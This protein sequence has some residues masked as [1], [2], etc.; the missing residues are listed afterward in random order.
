MLYFSSKGEFLF[1]FDS[2]R[3][4][5][6]EKQRSQAR[7]SFDADFCLG[8]ARKIAAAKIGNQLNLL[9]AFDENDLL[10]EEDFKRFGDALVNLEQ[11]RSVAEIMGIE[12]RLAK[13]YFYLLNLLVIDGFHF[14]DRSRRPAMDKFNTLLNFGYSI[15][16]SC[17]MGL[18]RKNGLSLGFGV[19]HQP[20][21][22]HAVLASDLMEE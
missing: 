13:S 2:F 6:F 9:Q 17:F 18:I 22:H 8:I 21:D 16:Y 15:L 14:S 1:S 19:M 5:D 3:K 7:A 10:D 4:E 11:A 12:G 20:H